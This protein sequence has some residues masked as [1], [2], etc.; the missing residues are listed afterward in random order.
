MNSYKVL[1]KEIYHREVEIWAD[2]PADAKEMVLC[3]DYNQENFE[4]S[5]DTDKIVRIKKVGGQL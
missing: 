4:L 1:V 2:S 5:H 3:G